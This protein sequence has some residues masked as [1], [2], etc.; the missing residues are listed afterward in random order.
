MD[1]APLVRILGT[2][3]DCH[4]RERPAHRAAREVMFVKVL[5]VDDHP[6]MLRGVQEIVA[7]VWP[8]ATCDGVQHAAAALHAVATSDGYALVCV[9]LNLPDLE[10]AELIRRLRRLRPMLP[11]I[12]LSAIDHAPGV[13]QAF[14]A[15]AQ[16]YLLKSLARDELVSALRQFHVGGHYLP[17]SLREALA[18]HR[19]ERGRAPAREVPRLT[20]RQFD[21][22]H[23]MALGLSNHDIGLR[24]SLS[25]ST[26]KGHVSCLLDLLDAD[27]RTA[28]ILNA[29]ALGL[30]DS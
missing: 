29:R 24:L 3:S 8:H 30:L 12:V 2:R 28:C 19:A 4:A 9:D 15:G 17:P 7:E 25:E 20:R 10:G 21:V 1:G 11:I 26:V 16:G 23:L 22:L 18:Q 14:D 13:Q 27:N 6:L 5:V